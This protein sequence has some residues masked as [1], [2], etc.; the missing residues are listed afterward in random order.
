MSNGDGDLV[1]TTALV[2]GAASGIGAA[3]A[4]ELA[5]RKAAVVVLDVDGSGAGR[6]AKSIG[7]FGGVA[8]AVT[9]DISTPEGRRLASSAAADLGGVDILVNNAAYHGERT[10]FLQSDEADWD[11]V[12]A[13][14]LS[15]AAA[16]CRACAPTMAERHRGSIINIAAIQAFLPVPTYVS[17]AA[18]KGGV[19]ALTRALAVE[20]SPLGVRVNAV[21]PGA[22]A[23]GSMRTA[24]AESGSVTTRAPTLLG[25]L[26]K[27]EEVATA[28]AFL[29]SPAASFVTG[30]VL[31]VDGGRNLSR[32]ADPLSGLG[33]RT[34]Q[35]GRA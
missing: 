23:T 14:N 31:V 8:E 22:I 17:Y 29:A 11:K 13:T 5:S 20:L 30:A 35:G 3:V 32:E 16:L 28:V 19:I 27:P 18:S 10:G 7:S 21:C 26:G 4:A 15:A 34:T 33:F 6:V 12:L 24:I 9:A 2:T 1:G 25:R